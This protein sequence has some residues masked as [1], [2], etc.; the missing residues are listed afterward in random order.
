[1]GS[2][3]RSLAPRAVPLRPPSLYLRGQ[4]TTLPV[5][6]AYIR[7]ARDQELKAIRRQRD[8][9]LRRRTTSLPVPED[10]PQQPLTGWKRAGTAGWR[11][12]A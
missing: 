3:V 7:R 6:V 1:M 10:V 9:L 8:E 4:A 12:T 5:L 11:R 2:R